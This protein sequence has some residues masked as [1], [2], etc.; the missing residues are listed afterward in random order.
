MPKP[1]LRV[2]NRRHYSTKTPGGRTVT[3]FYRKIGEVAICTI[4]GRPLHA[5][6][7]SPSSARKLPKTAKRPQRIYGGQICSSC[8]REMIKKAL[9]V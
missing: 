8:L 9:Y 1:A 5:P 3:H 2:R 7:L 6:R 4:C